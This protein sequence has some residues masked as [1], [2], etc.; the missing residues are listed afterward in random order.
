M[1]LTNASPRYAEFARQ[2]YFCTFSI[3]EA[4]LASERSLYEQ[5]SPPRRPDMAQ[6]FR[7]R[8]ALSGHIAPKVKTFFRVGGE[9]R[10]RDVCFTQ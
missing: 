5:K 4:G 3:R 6:S 9:N 1:L 8:A 2:A 7:N 10:R